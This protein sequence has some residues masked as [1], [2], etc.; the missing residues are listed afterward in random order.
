MT[1]APVTV[2]ILTAS[3]FNMA[4]KT[5][6]IDAFRACNYLAGEQLFRWSLSHA[7]IELP[8]ASNGLVLHSTALDPLEKAPDIGVVSTSWAPEAVYEAM[9]PLI[10]R[11]A[12][13]GAPL[14]GLDTGAF[15]L[16]EAGLLDGKRATVHYEHIDAF[17]ETF[18]N[19][20]TTEDLYTIDGARMT[21]AGGAAATDLALQIVR[22]RAG[23]AL[24]NVAARYIF[25]ER[26][27]PEGARQLPSG[28]EPSGA[29]TPTTVRAAIQFMEDHLE[30]VVPMHAIAAHAGISQRRL[31]RLFRRFIG[32]TPARY[33]RD[34]R[35]DRARGLAT[36]TDLPLRE[37]AL[38]CG[39]AS[40][41]HFSR[42]YRKRFGAPPQVDR[43]AGRVPFEF[44]AWPMHERGG[45]N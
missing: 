40:P 1:G 28:A 31:E 12:R 16:A 18:P 29:T 41:E 45:L 25:H 7:G 6:F 9:T 35:L 4:T 23:D 33:Y 26:L 39:F 36:Q 32:R 19:V 11:W 27:R 15:V 21:A 38:A 22:S 37:I 24:A 2:S 43:Q 3:G 10:R 44:R 34:V 5:G 13:F 17:A 8:V 30:D 42:A 20:R 14:V